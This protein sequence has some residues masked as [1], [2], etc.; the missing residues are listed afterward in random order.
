M[1]TP[2]DPQKNAASRAVL[3]LMTGDTMAAVRHVTAWLARRAYPMLG[4]V[5]LPGADGAGR[6]V[7]AVADDGRVE[8]LMVE[9]AGLPEV[10]AARLGHAPAS[11]L[12]LFMGGALAV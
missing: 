9:L 2:S 3:E 11:S 7:V 5:C 10:A 4:L 1:Q 12:A 6:L 8:R